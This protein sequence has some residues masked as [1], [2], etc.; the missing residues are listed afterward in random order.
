MLSYVLPTRNRPDQLQRTLA[1]LGNLDAA[2][3]DR[4]GGGEVIVIDNASETRP[5]LPRT[6]L[7]G[8]PLRTV[9]LDQNLGA[10]ARNHGVEIARGNWIVMLDDDSHPLDSR[11]VDVLLD[12]PHDVAA[13][14]A[15]IILPDGSRE[16]GGL[17]EVIIGC[18]AAIRR[19]AFL[20][21]GGYDPSFEYYVEEYDLCAKLQ[22]A[23]LRVLH[24][25]R[26]RVLHEKVT[27]GRDFNVIVR[28]LVRNNAWVMQRYAP[29]EMRQREIAH[30]I[31]RY[32]GIAMKEHA[33]GGYAMGIAELISSLAT[34]TRTPMPNE[35]WDR[36]TGASAVRASLAAVDE[37]ARVCIIEPGKNAEVIRREVSG[38]GLAL[39]EDCSSADI[40][41]IGTLSP[42]PMLD[43][44][45][46]H[47]SDHRIRMPYRI[48]GQQ[49]SA[50]NRMTG[51]LAA[52]GS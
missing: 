28:K 1:A 8:F 35:L 9:L 41:L 29:E 12:A 24:D 2:A 36:F 21:V 40:L 34:Q 25:L 33:A 20:S 10:A 22:L 6:L 23:A 38:A 48:Q 27:A 11:H 44:Y 50:P 49:S 16:R 45:D 42:G 5:A 18:G 31:E 17:P 3:H 43:A 51:M 13:I 4:F 39:C 46:R 14:G 19:E 37:G 26:F 32:A 15:E 30:T 47:R 7:N 52:T